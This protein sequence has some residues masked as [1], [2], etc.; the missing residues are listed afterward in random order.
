MYN[1]SKKIELK[2]IQHFQL[3]YLYLLNEEIWKTDFQQINYVE[4]DIRS[5]A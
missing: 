4:F 3:E 2:R 5:L 1:V